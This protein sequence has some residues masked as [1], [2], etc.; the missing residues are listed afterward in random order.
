[1]N[2]LLVLYFRLIILVLVGFTLGRKLPVKVTR[3]LGQVLFWV[4]V[5]ISIVAFLRKAELSGEVWIAP[6]IAYLAVFLGIILVLIALKTKKCFTQTPLQ[7]STVGSFILTSIVGNTGYLGFP[8]TL[9][10]VGDS[11]FAWA[12]FYDLLGN[13]FAA[14]GLGVLIG[15]RFSDRIQEN[16]QI[17]KAILINPALWSFGF[18]LAFRE[19]AIPDFFAALLDISAMIAI[20]LSLVLIG[21]R[22]SQLNSWDNLPLVTTSLTIKMLL[23]P[24]ILG[25]ALPIFGISGQAAKVIVL[26]MAMPPAFATLVIAETFNLDPNLCVSTLTL[27]S[28]LLLVTLPMW[29][30]LF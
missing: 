12:L 9:S 25:S 20:S 8:V 10:L 18:G 4:G 11:Y 5:P 24:L 3:Y 29:L 13:F 26:Q 1:M 2:N 23:I 28:I 15:A 30:W 19:L 27:G 22:L 14:Y 6:I 7:K 16:W 17:V 21:M